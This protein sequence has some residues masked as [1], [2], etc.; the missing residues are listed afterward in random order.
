MTREEIKI[1]LGM[2]TD[3][4]V[5]ELQT[6]GTKVRKGLN[7]VAQKFAGAFA[8]GSI[9]AGIKGLLDKFEALQTEADNLDISTDFLQGIQHLAGQ[10]VV[11]GVAKF[12]KALFELNRLLGDAKN[13]AADSQ[14]RFTDWG[15]AIED[16]QNLNTEEAFYLISDAMKAVPDPAKRAAMAVDLL[17]GS[18]AKMA[19]FISAGSDSLKKMVA[20]VDKL[21]ADK[22]KALA[23][24][25]HNLDNATRSITVAGGSAL[26][27]FVKL[28]EALGK[29]SAGNSIGATMGEAFR[30]LEA[31]S[32]QALAREQELEAFRLGSI[33][34]QQAIEDKRHAAEMKAANELE[35]QVLDRFKKER[36]AFNKLQEE[37]KAAQKKM[38]DIESSFAKI[39][40]DRNDVLRSQSDVGFSDAAGA[41]DA[42]FGELRLR[43][44][45]F[46]NGQLRDVNRARYLE[47][48]SQQARL[49]GNGALAD[50][51]QNERLGL[52]KGLGFLGESERNPFASL[53]EKFT[54]VR[55]SLQELLNLSAEKGLNVVINGV[56]E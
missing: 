21:D 16:I 9:A 56:N 4:A 36:D 48:E 28:A 46:N 50:K 33:A 55:D 39:Q 27:W 8:F 20:E 49:N 53:D 32:Q 29:M 17:G 13:G 7:D 45:V 31:E 5:R 30:K 10:N 41:A 43:P 1:T 18:G 11:G 2:S 15:I 23:D 22:V 25:Q 6:F 3:K 52:L 47:R 37:K 40:R 24:A 34:E 14:K 44:L 42:R 38:H 12:N 35:K 26:G 54:E 19:G 51:L